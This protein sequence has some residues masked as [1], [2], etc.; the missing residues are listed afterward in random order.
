M[1]INTQLDRIK[2]DLS[3]NIGSKVRLCSENEKKKKIIRNGVI[4]GTYP[5]IFVIK[6]EENPAIESSGRLISFSYADII[7]HNVELALCK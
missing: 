6:L 2:S 7:T 4:A 3:E 5:N 1:N